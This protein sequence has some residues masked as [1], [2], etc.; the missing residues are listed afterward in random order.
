[1]NPG[2]RSGTRR[3]DRLARLREACRK[4]VAENHRPQLARALEMT[5]SEL[6]RFLTRALTRRE[7]KQRK[8]ARK[9]GTA[10]LI[11]IRNALRDLPAQRQESAFS[12]FLT[13][14][15]AEYRAGDVPLPEW[16]Q[17]AFAGSTANPDGATSEETMR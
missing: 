6:A 16:L 15:L 17:H 3:G 11:I 7:R 1:M 9:R 12:T 8:Q 2:E 4:Q 13:T 14:L 5:A 10:G